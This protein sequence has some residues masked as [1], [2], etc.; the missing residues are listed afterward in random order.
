MTYL[1]SA[2]K[3]AVEKKCEICGIAFKRNPRYSAKQWARA[4]YC[5]FK[6]GGTASARRQ[7]FCIGNIPANKGRLTIRQCEECTTVSYRVVLYRKFNKLLCDKHAAHY[8]KYGRALWGTERPYKTP[9]A[10]R[11]KN[12]SKVG[13]AWRK[14][15][16]ERDDYTCQICGVRGVQIQA[17]HIKPYRFF[18]NLRWELSN[19]RVLCVP[20]HKKTPTYGRKLDN[21]AS[22]GDIESFFKTLV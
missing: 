3:D 13:I 18:P 21:L 19:G 2:I 15:V 1:K 7:G 14:A 8:R 17:D 5:S 22:G 20:C 9:I 11:E 4:R 6:C 10:R 12:L 16:F